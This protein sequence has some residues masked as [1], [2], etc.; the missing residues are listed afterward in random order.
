MSTSL[1]LARSM[2][3]TLASRVQVIFKFIRGIQVVYN[4]IFGLYTSHIFSKSHEL[5]SSIVIQVYANFM[6]FPE[7][8]EIL[9]GNTYDDR[10]K[11][12]LL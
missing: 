3:L 12:N 11:S 7:Y 9:K 5:I 2:A 4:T 8:F 1:N 10:I 6:G